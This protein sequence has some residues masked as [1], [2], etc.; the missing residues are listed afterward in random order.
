VDQ[1][2]IL[3]IMWLRMAQ[4]LAAVL[5]IG[6]PGNVLESIGRADRLDRAALRPGAVESSPLQRS[7]H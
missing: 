7:R 3:T 6:N 1:R 5:N 4:M 2:E